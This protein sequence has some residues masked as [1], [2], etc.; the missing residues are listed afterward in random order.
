MKFMRILILAFAVSPFFATALSAGEILTPEDA[1]RRA[2]QG[3]ITIV[4]VR[5]PTEWRQTGIP[6][7]A[8]AVT[9]HHPDGETGFVAAMD[10]ALNGD[11]TRPIALICAA[12]ARSSRAQRWL[13][14][15]G[16]TNVA[17]IAE[18][19]LGRGGDAPGWIARDLPTNPCPVC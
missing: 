19:M 14:T 17:D 12:G 13:E 7:H 9:I 8:I 6:E 4:D 11:R 16:F 2:A 1:F 3:E 10:E 15:H 18:G 5:S